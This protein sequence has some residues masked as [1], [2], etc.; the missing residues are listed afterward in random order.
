MLSP[1]TCYSTLKK[2]DGSKK[3]YYYSPFEKEFPLLIKE[4]LR[5]KHKLIFGMDDGFEFSISPYH[6]SPR[7][8]K[9]IIYNR[10]SNDNGTVIKAWMGFYEITGSPGALKLA[11]DVG[12]GAKNPQ[13]FG[14][15][16]V[17]SVECRGEHPGYIFRLYIR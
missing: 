5:K 6:V 2:A 12:L 1:L 14:C 4:N 16:E 17:T 7:D 9:I 8:Q 15:W 11:Y 13:G 10:T 3:T